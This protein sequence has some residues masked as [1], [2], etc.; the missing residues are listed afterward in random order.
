MKKIIVLSCFVLSITLCGCDSGSSNSNYS[1]SN[2]YNPSFRGA[3]VSRV[4]SLNSEYGGVTYDYGTFY[5]GQMVVVW[6]CMRLN[7]Y[8]SDRSNWNYMIKWNDG[9]KWYFD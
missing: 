3:G 4:V 6:N 1:E 5:E 9:S 7:V 2:G 8:R